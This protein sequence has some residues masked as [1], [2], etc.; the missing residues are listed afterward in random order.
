[1]YALTYIREQKYQL[2]AVVLFVVSFAVLVAL[3]SNATNQE[4]LAGT[5]GYIAVLLIFVNQNH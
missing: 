3:G 1:M 5:A 4:V 2:M